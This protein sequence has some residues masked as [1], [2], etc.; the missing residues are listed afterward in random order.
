AAASLASV[1]SLIRSSHE[2]W[3]GKG[4]PDGLAGESIPLASRIILVADAYDAMTT[5][6]PYSPARSP[7]GALA[8]LREGAG[9]QFDPAV[10]TAP[11][12]V[13]RPTPADRLLA[14]QPVA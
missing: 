9:T 12:H 8:E 13:V 3:D 5:E 14:P 4:Y 10:V 11:E 7:E 2:R 6:R 1:G